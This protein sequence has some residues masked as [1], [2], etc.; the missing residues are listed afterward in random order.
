MKSRSPWA[1]FLMA[2]GFFVTAMANV[3][4]VLNVSL[5]V[6]GL[7]IAVACGIYLFTRR[8]G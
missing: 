3:T 1:V 5:L 6:G 4:G 7:V 8:R 2:V